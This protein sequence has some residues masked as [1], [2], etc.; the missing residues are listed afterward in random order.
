M[1]CFWPECWLHR[2]VH[3]AKVHRDVYIWWFTFLKNV[4]IIKK[5]TKKQSINQMLAPSMTLANRNADGCRSLV[6]GTQMPWATLLS[7]LSFFLKWWALGKVLKS[8]AYSSCN[9]HDS[10]I[11][12]QYKQGFFSYINILWGTHWV[13]ESVENRAVPCYARPSCPFQTN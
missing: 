1:F 10:C 8:K 11:S 3:F 12:D 2:C 6:L 4:V 13:P 5:F 7:V 9:L